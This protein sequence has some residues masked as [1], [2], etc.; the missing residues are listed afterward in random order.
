MKYSAKEVMQ[1]V[2]EEDVKFIRLAFCDVYG[3]QKNISIM[4]GELPRAFRHGVAIDASAIRG[5][6]EE[7]HSDLFL[8]PDPSTISV[9]PWRPGHGRV[10][11]MFCDVRLPDGTPFDADARGLYVLF[12][13]GA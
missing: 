12:R 2:A 1:Y 8:H 7:N 10:V 5:F 13:L 6:G 11:R 9:L 4:P 3:K